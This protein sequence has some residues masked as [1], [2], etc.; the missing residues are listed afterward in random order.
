VPSNTIDKAMGWRDIDIREK[1]TGEPFLVF[2]GPVQNLP[3]RAAWRLRSS[4]LAIPNI[5][6]SPA[7]CLT[8]SISD[9]YAN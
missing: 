6:L 8:A 1:P 5:T 4:H 3:Q 2:S 9:R 7:L